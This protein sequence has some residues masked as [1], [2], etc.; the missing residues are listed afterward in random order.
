MF[1]DFFFK[2][3]ETF[4]P[5]ILPLDLSELETIPQKAL[6]ALETYKQVN[7]LINNA[8][9]SFRGNIVETS[10]EVHMK[11]MCVNYFGQIALTK[12]MFINIKQ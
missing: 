5:V 8:G 12:G 2:E 6:E 11:V 3:S 4:E 7:I 1:N 10:L 9:I